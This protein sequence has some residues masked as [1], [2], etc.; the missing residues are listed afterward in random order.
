MGTEEI[1]FGAKREDVDS[2]SELCPYHEVGAAAW[3]PGA[4]ALP[5]IACH[6]GESDE[7]L[8]IGGFKNFPYLKKFYKAELLINVIFEITS[9]SLRK[10]IS[11]LLTLR[12]FK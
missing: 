9:C 8:G 11:F 3:D 12:L 5:V 2:L 4:A 1:A 6:T 10:K 7:D